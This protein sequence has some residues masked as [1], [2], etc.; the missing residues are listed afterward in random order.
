MPARPVLRTGR[1]GSPT[2]P[3][4][5]IPCGADARRALPEGGRGT[6]MTKLHQAVRRGDMA[7]VRDRVRRGADPNERDRQG[8]TMLHIAVGKGREPRTAQELV[9][10]GCDPDARDA[11]GRSPLD[12]AAKAGNIPAAAVL[13]GAGAD[14]AAPDAEGLAPATRLVRARVPHDAIMK[15]TFSWGEQ[16]EGFVRL[17][18]PELAGRLDFARMVPLQSEFALETLGLVRSD[19]IRL[20]PDRDGG[21]GCMPVLEFQSRPDREMPVRLMLYASQAILQLRR[22]NRGAPVPRPLPIVIAT[23]E[24][25]WP[26]GPKS[27]DGLLAPQPWT[28]PPEVSLSFDLTDLAD[29][30]LDLSA[31]DN[32]AAACLRAVR[33]RHEGIFANLDGI[34]E[35]FQDIGR[36]FRGPKYASLRAVMRAAVLAGTDLEANP[37]IIPLIQE[38]G[39]MSRLAESLN[40]AMARNRQEGLSQGRS[41]G[42]REGRS[43]GRREGRSEEG[44]EILSEI[45]EHRFG[46]D[47]AGAL[48]AHLAR[49][50]DPDA[51]RRS[52]L[53]LLD[54]ASGAEVLARLRNNGHDPGADGP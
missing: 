27:L 16:I 44:V 11:R 37:G 5:R 41:E 42:R 15:L 6:G 35:A 2:D 32:P 22:T 3:A 1:R 7:P 8:R 45:A 21:P 18:F 43:E 20:I 24:R 50:G 39:N 19:L 48:R 46:P 30:E 17:R 29:P 49:I 12:V 26:D 51:V 52:G 28:G 9:A 54:C 13:L 31:P 34:A 38:E 25:R 33:L 40:E 53:A 14:A 4:D 10:L 23:G 47:V 36:I